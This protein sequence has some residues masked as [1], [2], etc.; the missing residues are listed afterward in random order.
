MIGGLGRLAAVVVLFGTPS[1]AAQEH[2]RPQDQVYFGLQGGLIVPAGAELTHFSEE[3]DT[4]SAPTVRG[5]PSAVG[6]YVVVW[7][8]SEYL[9][10]EG[11]F[12]GFGLPLYL[13]GDRYARC[14]API[15]GRCPKTADYGGFGFQVASVARLGV[16][17]RFVHPNLSIGYTLPVTI[18]FTQ[19]PQT[20]LDDTTFEV[21]AA[22]RLGGGLGF[23]V[24]RQW[25]LYADYRFDYRFATIQATSAH[26]DA[27]G[28]R[29]HSV[30]LGVAYSPDG[31]REGVSK[32]TNVF[33]PFLAAF[34]PWVA[35]LALE[36]A[37]EDGAS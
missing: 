33:L 29:A 7:W 19:D 3:G 21:G 28:L 10:L 25:R 22:V 31:Y 11:G 37:T 30:V 4:V 34:A 16:P 1:V 35:A 8:P 18:Q 23:Y 12:E 26:V 6:G 2:V 36:V 32:A 9:A 13:P 15:G 20:R 24:A 17:L 14:S 5:S 27:A